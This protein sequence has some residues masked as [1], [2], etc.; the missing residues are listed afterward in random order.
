LKERQYFPQAKKLGIPNPKISFAPAREHETFNVS[1]PAGTG[2]NRP[3]LDVTFLIEQIGDNFVKLKPRVSL[4][5]GDT[6]W[7]LPDPPPVTIYANK[8]HGM[9][10][11]VEVVDT[12]GTHSGLAGKYVVVVVMALLDKL[13]R[14]L[15]IASQRVDAKVG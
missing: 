15:V 9:D 8:S 6:V 12:P 3:P 2:E 4:R 5:R 11:N 13:E 14:N 7:N 1:Y 10:F